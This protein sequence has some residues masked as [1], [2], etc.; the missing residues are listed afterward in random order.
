[1]ASTWGGTAIPAPTRY[2]R[3]TQHV[4]AQ[5][6]VADG[7]MVTDTITSKTAV[8]LEFGP[9]TETE[10][11]TLIG[12]FTTF[13][14]AALIIESETTENVIPVANSLRVS[15][16]QGGTRAYIVSGQVRTA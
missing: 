16:L 13:T 11:N 3:Q 14:S 9:V 2:D 6:I 12:K 4:G 1:M 7:S 8:D 10:R 5:F 15:R